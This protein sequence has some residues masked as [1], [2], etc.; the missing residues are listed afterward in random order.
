MQPTPLRGEKIV[1]ILASIRARTSF[2]S[3]GG[4]AADGHSVGSRRINVR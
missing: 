1:A 4:G 2:R 3:L